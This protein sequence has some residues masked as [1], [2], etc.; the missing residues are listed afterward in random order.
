MATYYIVSKNQKTRE[1]KI[2]TSFDNIND[3]REY[4]QD[5]NYFIA[6]DHE[7][8]IEQGFIPASE[9]I[10]NSVEDRLEAEENPSDIWY[11]TYS[12][13]RGEG[14]NHATA[15]KRADEAVKNIGA[16]Q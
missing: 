9:A 3:A 12:M 14:A 5:T 11:T 2:V 13:H 10:E 8:M 15:V 1:S 4:I 7:A 6:Y 16:I